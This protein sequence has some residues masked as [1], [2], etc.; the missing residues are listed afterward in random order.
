M[1]ALRCLSILWLLTA[2]GAETF[3]TQDV[4]AQTNTRGRKAAN[5]KAVHPTKRAPIRRSVTPPPA[6]GTF[7][8]PQV[9][10]DNW[11]NLEQGEDYYTGA[12]T[13]SHQV[14]LAFALNYFGTGAGLEYLYRF[15]SFSLGGTALYTQAKLDDKLTSGAQN[16][17]EAIE[18]FDTKSAFLRFNGRYTFF[19][20]VY[21]G[22]GVSAGQVQ[23]SYGWRGTAFSA[24]EIKSD[25]KA[26]VMAADIFVGS[27]FRGPWGTY[28]GVDWLGTSLPFSSTI[29]YDD[30]A[31]L[32]LTSN[33]LKGHKPSQRIEDETKAQLQIYYLNLRFGIAF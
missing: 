32:D 3:L 19:R 22:A 31:D 25:F 4:Y 15:G 14:G 21:L 18:F 11:Y 23:G 20:Y 27:E 30:N 33:A 13:K 6:A 26:S 1:S 9:E 16:Q 8:V 2:T 12:N 7:A 28:F 10:E 5:P 24:G 29:T 17:N